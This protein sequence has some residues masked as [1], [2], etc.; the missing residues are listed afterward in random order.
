[1]AFFSRTKIGLALGSG[2]ARGLAHIGVIKV[3]ERYGVPIDYIAGS[4]AGSLVGGL[5]A[6]TK[7][8]HK[9]EK[10]ASEITFQDFLKV[11]IDPSLSKG[12]IKG[13]KFTDYLKKQFGTIKIEDC[14]IPFKAVT[15]DVVTGATIGITKGDLIDAIRTS[16]SIPLLFKPMK[17]RKKILVDGG[18][19]QPVPVDTVKDMGAEKVIAVNLNHTLFADKERKQKAQKMNTLQLFIATID[20]MQHYLSRH[21]VKDADIVL[22]PRLPSTTPLTKFIDGANLIKIGEQVTEKKIERI[23]DLVKFKIGFLRI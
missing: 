5:Y 3:L 16:S 6:A 20:I 4:S 1:M 8:I 14:K 10:L 9:I 15:T 7:D 12:L 17:K 22:N 21:N 19:S 11:I 18:T 23:K 2:G 13:T